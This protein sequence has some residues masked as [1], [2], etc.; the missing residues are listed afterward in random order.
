MFMK[1][2]IIQPKAWSTLPRE[3]GSQ[4]SQMTLSEAM[5]DSWRVTYYPFLGAA[6]TFKG[7]MLPYAD[8]YSNGVTTVLA[9]TP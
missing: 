1:A 3:F 5:F 4:T 8:V 9:G 2:F 7:K 6:V